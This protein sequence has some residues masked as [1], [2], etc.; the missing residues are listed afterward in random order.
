MKKI[1]YL[2]FLFIAGFAFAQKKDKIKGSKIITH[3]VKELQAVTHIEIEDN[4]KIFLV[5]S[6]KFS[7]E[8]EADDNLHDVLNISI[9]ANTLR[10]NTL[11]DVSGAKKFEIRLNYNDTLQEITM[12]HDA[13]LNALNE[14]ELKNIV[15]RNFD[16]S[17]SFLNVKSEKFSI[18]MND[19][20]E[21]ELNIKADTCNIQGSKYSVLKALVAAPE[22]KIDLYEK[23]KVTIE[24]DAANAQIR[25]DNNSTLVAK[26][27]V[28][29]SINLTTENF[30]QSEL[31]ASKAII[32]TA[33]GKSKTE[34]YGA[35]TITIEKFVNTTILEKKEL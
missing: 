31:N 24:G 30:A 13:I 34:L 11:K 19:K 27:F 28:V 14:L 4:V 2:C 17:K 29:D 6:D 1:I 8:I 12:K 16:N 26:K 35:P 3:T 33:S 10:I 22:T 9:L 5:K 23:A 25:I 21:A 18:F 32:I 7:L 15:I 20:S